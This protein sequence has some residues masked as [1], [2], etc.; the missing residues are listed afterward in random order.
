M[1]RVKNPETGEK[2]RDR[3]KEMTNQNKCQK[4][5]NSNNV[6]VR[7]N[8]VCVVTKMIIARFYGHIL[9]DDFS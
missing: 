7:S 4:N 2:K 1:S 3:K 5:H 9:R 8:V 6:H